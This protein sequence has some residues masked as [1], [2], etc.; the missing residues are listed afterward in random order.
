MPGTF[1]TED[2]PRGIAA[3]K[4]AGLRCLAVRN[5]FGDDLLGDADW[6]VD[7]LGEVDLERLS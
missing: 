4:A 2:S 1:F 5:S 6:I 7:S 3:A